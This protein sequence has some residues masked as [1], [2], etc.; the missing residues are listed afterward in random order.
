[1][2]KI[3]IV[4]ELYG[5]KTVLIIGSYKSYQDYINKRFGLN[6]EVEQKYFGGETQ[7]LESSKEYVSVI[8][9]PRFNASVDSYGTLAHEC[10][11]V[12]IRAMDRLGIPIREDNQEPIAYYFEFLFTELLSRL[13]KNRKKLR[14]V[15]G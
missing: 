2:L 3:E 6:D 4:S 13:I 8:W 11:H 1:M 5:L 15:R 9:L 7:T 12:A 14:K 10:L